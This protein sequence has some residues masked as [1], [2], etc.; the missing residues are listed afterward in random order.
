MARSQTDV[1]DREC[2]LGSHCGQDL[3]SDPVGLF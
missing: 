1:W 3:G 2:D